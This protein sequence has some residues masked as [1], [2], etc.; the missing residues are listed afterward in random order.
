MRGTHAEALINTL[1]E[2]NMPY[3]HSDTVLSVP[4]L[5]SRRNEKHYRIVEVTEGARLELLLFSHKWNHHHLLESLTSQL[6]H[7][8]Q[9]GQGH[10]ARVLMQLQSGVLPVLFTAILIKAKCLSK[11][12]L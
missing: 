1:C 6:Q 3:L 2:I 5:W 4:Q 9:C 11:S 12:A 7:R 8:N 10:T